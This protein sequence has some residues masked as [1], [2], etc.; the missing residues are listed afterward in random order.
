VLRV[1]AA[2]LEP[3]VDGSET[4]AAAL[5]ELDALRGW[6]GLGDLA[7][8]PRGDLASELQRLAG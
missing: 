2:F 5:A 8:A 6:L 1:T 3:G 4:A 7:V